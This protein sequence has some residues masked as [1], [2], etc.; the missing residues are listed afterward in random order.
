MTVTDFY[1]AASYSSVSLR[2]CDR[3]W[4]ADEPRVDGITRAPRRIP[5]FWWLLKAGQDPREGQ[6]LSNCTH[7]LPRGLLRSRS[8]LIISDV[9]MLMILV[10]E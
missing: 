3:C 1:R 5:R 2:C 6:E 7:R 8:M 4:N 9:S 10:E